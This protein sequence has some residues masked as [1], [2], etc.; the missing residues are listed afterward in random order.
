MN[1]FPALLS[2]EQ[3]YIS[4]TPS[5]SCSFCLHHLNSILLK[6]DL[7]WDGGFSCKALRR[8]DAWRCFLLS[9]FFPLF[10]RSIHV[11]FWLFYAKQKLGLSARAMPGGFGLSFN[12]GRESSK[13]AVN[14]L[15]ESLKQQPAFAWDPP[16]CT[17]W[18]AIRALYYIGWKT[19]CLWNKIQISCAMLTNY[20]VGHF[21]HF[22]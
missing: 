5:L 4:L 2:L 13:R 6:C 8:S 14:W 22:D 7:L 3:K 19:D 17:G 9:S 15:A 16:P 12:F 20:V 18:W 1:F 21:G 10:I 11:W